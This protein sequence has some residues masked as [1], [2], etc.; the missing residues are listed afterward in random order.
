MTQE[1]EVPGGSGFLLTAVAGPRQKRI[2]IIILSLSLIGFVCGLPFVRLQLPEVT[3]FI[4]AY[5]GALGRSTSS[6]LSCCLASLWSFARGRC[7]FLP[8]ATYSTPRWSCRTRSHFR[9]CSLRPASW[10]RGRKQPLGSISSG[11]RFSAVRARLRSP[12]ALRDSSDRKRPCAGGL[13]RLRRS[14]RP[15]NGFHDPDDVGH[16]LLPVIVQNNVYTPGLIKGVGPAIWGS[17][18]VAWRFFGSVALR[19]CSTCG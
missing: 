10:R 5:G 4:P 12:C 3:A 19:L 8:P 16:D 15:C 11:I 6:S 17:A 7:S 13:R 1:N 14:D 18:L 2:I 9:E